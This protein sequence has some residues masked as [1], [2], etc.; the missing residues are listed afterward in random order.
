MIIM[1]KEQNTIGLSRDFIIHPG[2]TLAEVLEDREMSQ[3]ELAIRTG[4]TEKHISTV[5]NGQ[6]NISSSFAKKLEYAL[7]IET[8]FWMNLQANYERELLEFEELN[9]ISE[10]EMGILK[11]LKEVLA[12]WTEFGWIEKDANPASTVLDVRKLFGISNLLDTPKMKYAAA[13]R[14]QSKNTNIDPYVLFAWQR[15]C[16]LLTENIDVAEVVDLELLRTKI[17]EIKQVMFL[18]A[19]QIQRKLTSIFAEC[20]IAFRIVPNFKGAPV[21]GFIKTTEDGALILCMTL[22]QKFADIFWFTLFHEISHILNG[23]TKNDFVDFDSVSGENEA[24]AD[25]MAGEFL[26]DSTAYKKFILDKKYIS[27]RGI[28]EFAEEQNVRDYIIQGRL[29][30]EEIIPWKARPRY[31]WA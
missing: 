12:K 24:K 13:F 30:K 9:N 27:S 25:R 28:D 22:R 1:E 23:D 10:Q 29:M 3:K 26:I 4:V 11:N 7:G 6:K 18:R 15:M 14:V 16:E 19:N 2:E 17:P 5:I 20:G 8:G 21:Q 31:E